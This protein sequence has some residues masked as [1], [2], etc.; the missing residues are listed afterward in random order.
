MSIKSDKSSLSIIKLIENPNN[1]YY[2]SDELKKL[3]PTYFKGT[4]KTIRKIIERKNIPESEYIYSTT[5]KKQWKLCD[6]SCKKG[7]LLITKTWFDSHINENNN[8][9][10]VNNNSK[11]NDCNYENDYESS[12]DEINNDYDKENNKNE[13][14]KFDINNNNNENE[15]DNFY[16]NN[17]EID[18]DINYENCE[19]NDNK[20]YD[21]C[22]TNI[23]KN[24]LKNEYYV[25]NSNILNKNKVNSKSKFN[26]NYKNELFNKK[27]KINKVENK[28]NYKYLYE[29]LLKETINESKMYNLKTENLQLQLE[30]LKL[31]LELNKKFINK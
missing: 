3:Y 21:N 10:N 22:D 20:I 16:I 18:Y 17:N 12:E 27:L 29:S 14:D 9:I 25:N 6:K 5:F 24:E 8:I 26:N 28:N 13:S 2:I 4:S 31:Q 30:N 23:F 7:K 19:V 11:F 1:E 15:S